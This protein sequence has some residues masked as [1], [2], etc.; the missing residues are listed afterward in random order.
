MCVNGAQAYAALS[1]ISSRP[2][3]NVFCA[4][5]AVFAWIPLYPDSFKRFGC[6]Y[7]AIGNSI[8]HRG[9]LWGMVKSDICKFDALLIISAL[10]KK[11]GQWLSGTQHSRF[12]FTSTE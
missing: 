11:G 9:R 8:G 1:S 3:V 7:I 12:S 2:A 4:H 10:N 5:A 6:C